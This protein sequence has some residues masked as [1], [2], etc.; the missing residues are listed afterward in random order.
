MSS[1]VAGT[2]MAR[3]TIGVVP[4][5]GESSQFVK[6]TGGRCSPKDPSLLT[7]AALRSAGQSVQRKPG[8][9]ARRLLGEYML[10][11]AAPRHAR[12][13]RWPAAADHGDGEPCD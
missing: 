13:C 1:N 8:Q 11:R 2:A 4:T 3:L 6:A 12:L 9:M 7:A 5:T 10:D